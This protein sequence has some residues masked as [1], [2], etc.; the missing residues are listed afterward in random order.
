MHRLIT[1]YMSTPLTVSP[2]TPACQ[3]IIQSSALSRRHANFV[4]L[5]LAG[6]SRSRGRLS[7]YQPAVSPLP[8]SSRRPRVDPP[9]GTPAL[10]ILRLGIEHRGTDGPVAQQFLDWA[11]I[12]IT[13]QS[14]HGGTM[15]QGVKS[16]SATLLLESVEIRT[17]RFVREVLLPEPRREGRPAQRDACVRQP[18]MLT[19]E[20]QMVA[21]LVHHQPR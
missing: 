17:E 6:I 9:S 1:K 5:F 21:K 7:R 14:A 4:K 18:R 12:T 8:I 13:L 10:T 11:S 2:A 15:T 3:H 19:I 16:K 20:Q